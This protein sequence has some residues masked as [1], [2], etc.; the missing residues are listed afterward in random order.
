MSLA[1]G[2]TRD[3]VAA[4][5]MAVPAIRLETVLEAIPAE[6]IVELLKIDAQGFDLDVFL[7]AGR[8]IERLGAV[9]LEVQDLAEDDVGV[10]YENASLFADVQ[11]SMKSYGFVLE[12]CEVQNCAIREYNCRFVRA[13][14]RA[15][16][17][18]TGKAKRR[19]GFEF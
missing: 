4:L 12:S 7:S 15:P 10:L 6:A 13:G 16:P 8:H 5:P 1:E 2:C 3:Q 11:A 19:P 9:Q 18:A 17:R 14:A